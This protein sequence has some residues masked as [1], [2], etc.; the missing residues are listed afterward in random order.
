MRQQI[1]LGQFAQFTI[2]VPA[3]LKPIREKQRGA[4]GLS[5]EA[6]WCPYSLS[7][8]LI[9]ICFVLDWRL[10]MVSDEEQAAQ[11]AVQY[12]PGIWRH[13]ESSYTAFIREMEVI[14]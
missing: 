11:Q 7:G 12:Q 4:S 2:D 14:D 5:P 6:R 13:R 1:Q 8:G 3:P 9:G 10:A